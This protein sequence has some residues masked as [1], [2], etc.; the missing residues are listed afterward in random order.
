MKKRWLPYVIFGL[1]FYLLFLVIE[2]PASWF[3]WGLNRYTNG[4][5]R[6]D[7]IA[8]SL[9]HGNGRL[10]IFYP[11]SVPHD[12]GNTE[13]RI[14]PLWLFAGRVHVSLESNTRD[15]QIKTT[16]NIGQKKFTVTDTDAT[17]PAASIGSFY[18]PA[19]LIGPQGRV[20]FHT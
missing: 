6:L 19:T 17:F 7:A 10:V 20:K 4:A 16:L 12:F 8:G 2:M 5:L 13:W 18:Q 11:K 14:N 1:V 15:A 3:A 9:W